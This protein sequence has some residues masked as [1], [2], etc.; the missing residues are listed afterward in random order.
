[1]IRTQALRTFVTVADCGN[2]R[3]AA[4]ILGRTISA[5]SMTLRQLEEQIGAPLFESDRKNSLS[6]LGEEVRSLSRNLLRE[7]DRTVERIS[8]LAKGQ[9]GILRIAAVPSVAAHLLPPVLT[10]MLAEHPDIRIELTDT[11]SASIQTLLEK[12]EVEIGIGGAPPAGAGLAFTALFRDP[13]RL[14]CRRDHPLAGEKRPLTPDRI[15][16]LRLIRNSS[17]SGVSW[18]AEIEPAGGGLAGGGLAGGGSVRARNVISLLALVRAGAGVTILPALATLSISPD[19]CA[20][21]L[22][23]ATEP[24][25]V[26]FLQRQDASPSP[27]C[28]GFRRRFEDHMRSDYRDLL[29]FDP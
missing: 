11:D 28:A 20:L 15:K 1:M 26:G 9:A 3:D 7:H 23:E 16:G 21:P 2:I 22:A 19:L 4:A 12:R 29:S 24:R 17:T 27:V 14:V 18:L 5:I 25:I 10:A 6:R 13:F 8:A